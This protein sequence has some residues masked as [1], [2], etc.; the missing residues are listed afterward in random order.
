[1]VWVIPQEGEGI[2]LEWCKGGPP[3]SLHVPKAAVFRVFIRTWKR[4][5]VIRCE[6]IDD[7]HDGVVRRVTNVLVDIVVSK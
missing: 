4:C 2:V 3:L 7:V 1:M 6:C 5:V